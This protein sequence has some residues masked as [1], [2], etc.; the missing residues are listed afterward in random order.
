[1]REPLTLGVF[2]RNVSHCWSDSATQKLICDSHAAHEKYPIILL[3][4]LR[5]QIL[6]ELFFSSPEQCNGVQKV[7]IR[8]RD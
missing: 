4:Q 1:M 7:K 3:R 5:S 8:S 6:R 2:Q